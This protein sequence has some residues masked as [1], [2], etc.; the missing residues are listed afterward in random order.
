LPPEKD[1]VEGVRRLKEAVVKYGKNKNL[2]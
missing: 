1:I 2:L